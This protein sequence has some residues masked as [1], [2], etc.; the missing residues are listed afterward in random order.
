M[1]EKKRG[2]PSG[3]HKAPR[4]PMMLPEGWLKVVQE[5]AAEK[6]MPAMWYVVSLVKEQ[7][8]KAAK[9]DLPSAPWDITAAG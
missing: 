3:Q 1:A 8:E 6:Q 4:K 7:A 2:R 5:L 9:P